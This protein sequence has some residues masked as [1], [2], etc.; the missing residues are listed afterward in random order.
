MG[1]VLQYV[2]IQLLLPKVLLL[3]SVLWT[4]HPNSLLVMP[5]AIEHPGFKAHREP[6]ALLSGGPHA[7][8]AAIFDAIR[9][10]PVPLKF[11][12]GI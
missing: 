3:A 7:V 12:L 1:I 5:I 9:W 11:N 2:C 10:P 4:M 8:M 6:L